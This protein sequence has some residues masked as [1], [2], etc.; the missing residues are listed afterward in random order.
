MNAQGRGEGTLEILSFKIDGGR[1]GR[2]VGPRFYSERRENC[3]RIEK[4]C[5]FIRSN[6]V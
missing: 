5:L 2:R 4:S 1:D 6:R 3:G